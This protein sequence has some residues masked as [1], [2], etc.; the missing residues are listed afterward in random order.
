MIPIEVLQK[1]K[2]LTDWS[3]LQ[4][5][6]GSQAHGT[7]IKPTE[8]MGTDDK[9]I[10]SICVLPEDYYFGLRVYGSRGTKE[11][12]HDVWDIVIYDIRKFISLLAKGNP[13]VLMML[14]LPEK[15]YIRRTKAGALLIDNRKMFAT[16]ACYKAFVGYASGQLHR[17]THGKCE[18]YMGIKRKALVQRFG[19][20]CKNAAH[21]IRLLRMGVEFLSTGELIVERPDASELIEIKKGQWELT[22]IQSEAKELFALSKE[23]LIHS[24]L[25]IAP[26]MD[27]INDLCKQTIKAYYGTKSG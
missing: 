18:G 2:G 17:M 23:A 22:R 19:Y 13:N 5:Y 11:L 3:I 15:Y 26:N 6:R 4:G 27:A 7:Y 21:L 12:K 20:D 24:P 9:D 1:D 14:W 8:P 16:R 25:P 10:M